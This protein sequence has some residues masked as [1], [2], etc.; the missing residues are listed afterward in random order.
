M[1]DDTLNVIVNRMNELKEE[2]EELKELF[3]LEKEKRCIEAILRG[4]KS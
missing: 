3:E 4:M 1:I 2:Q